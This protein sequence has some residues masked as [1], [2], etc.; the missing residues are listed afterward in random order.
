[1]LEG[2]E[3]VEEVVGVRLAPPFSRWSPRL[4]RRR[5][6]RR[7]QFRRTFVKMQS[8]QKGPEFNAA[9]IFEGEPINSSQKLVR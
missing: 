3:E 6:R 9:A 1:V 2:E 7:R 8:T 4:H 5:R